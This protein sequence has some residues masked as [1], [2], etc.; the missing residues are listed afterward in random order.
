MI[1]LNKKFS[2][3]NDL[4]NPNFTFSPITDIIENEENYEINLSLAG[5]DKNNLILEVEDNYLSIKGSKKS[6]KTYTYR[7]SYDSEFEK[8]FYLPKDANKENI[9]ADFV[10]GVLLVTIP[11]DKTKIIKRKIEL[12]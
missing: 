1:Q 9:T 12:K 8:K 10:N 2:T 7:E 5:F 3:L 4:L 11:K 6:S